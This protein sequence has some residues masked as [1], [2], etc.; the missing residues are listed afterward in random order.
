MLLP[1][2][3]GQLLFKMN[4][5]GAAFERALARF[6]EDCLWALDFFWEES[7]LTAYVEL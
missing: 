1:K 6:G 2:E 5:W 3:S 7:P 4:G